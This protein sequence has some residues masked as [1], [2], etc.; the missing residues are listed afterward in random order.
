MVSSAIMYFVLLCLQNEQYNL[1]LYS[2][3]KLEL[4]PE[5]KDLITEIQQFMCLNLLLTYL[6]VSD[7]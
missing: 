6:R 2:D 7:L 1:K 3:K 4:S 5:T